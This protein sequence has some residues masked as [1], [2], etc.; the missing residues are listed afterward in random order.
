MSQCGNTPGILRSK[1]T[2]W[3]ITSEGDNILCQLNLLEFF[4]FK[5]CTIYVIWEV[6]NIWWLY[7]FQRRLSYFP[8][9]LPISP[10]LPPSHLAHCTS[11]IF[12]LPWSPLLSTCQDC[13]RCFLSS[14]YTIWFFSDWKGQKFKVYVRCFIS[15]V[16]KIHNDL[17]KPAL[18]IEGNIR[19]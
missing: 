4:R 3:R 6:K 9:H 17:T 5:F 13:S 8:S 10:S 2:T 7:F 16:R 15:E 12:N 18:T 1:C 14:P 19:A 11:G